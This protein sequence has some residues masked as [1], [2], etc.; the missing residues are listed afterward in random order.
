MKFYIKRI[1]ALSLIGALSFGTLVTT[2]CYGTFPFARTIWEINRDIS[3]DKFVQWLVFLGLTVVPVY[4]VALLLDVLVGNSVEFWTGESVLADE[5]DPPDKK[6]VELSEG[7]TAVMK[8]LDSKHLHV[9]IFEDG[10]VTKEFI[11][12][13]RGDMLVLRNAVGEFLGAASDAQDGG[14]NVTDEEGRILEHHDASSVK[15]LRNT[16]DEQGAE[17]ANSF[18]V[19]Y[20][21]RNVPFEPTMLGSVR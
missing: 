10:E 2:G 14:I 13:G 8:R 16:L 7:R 5:Q 6:V 17:G 18:A 4:E 11:V 3:N 9:T 15:Q 19:Q 20:R 1:L 12:D 21:H